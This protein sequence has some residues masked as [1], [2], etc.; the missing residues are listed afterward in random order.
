MK[1]LATGTGANQSDL[2]YSDQ[3]TLNASASETLDLTAL[4]NAFGAAINFAKVKAILIKASSGNTNNV[5]YGNAT[6]PFIGPLSVGT[7]TISLPPD[8]AMM[9]A[10]PGSGWTVTGGS[11]DEIKIAN[12]AGSTTVT[13]DIIII[14]TSA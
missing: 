2:I 8:G 10:A 1:S 12:S 14:G 9:L 5:A 11:A 6:A 13:Y 7:A 4:T 3:R